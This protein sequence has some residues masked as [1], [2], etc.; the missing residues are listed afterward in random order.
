MICGDIT[1]DSI[2]DSIVEQAIEK[3]IEWYLNNKDWWQ[4]LKSNV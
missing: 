1:D 2:R 4:P 3:T